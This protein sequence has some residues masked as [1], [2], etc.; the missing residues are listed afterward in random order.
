M[1]SCS[2]LGV[3]RT[4]LTATCLRRRSVRA[5]VRGPGEQQRRRERAEAAR[6]R[7]ALPFR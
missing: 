1:L 3:S 6:G 4:R 2:W 5:A 7:R